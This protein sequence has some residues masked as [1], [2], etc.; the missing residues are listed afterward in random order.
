MKKHLTFRRKLIFVII[1][2]AFC[3]EI[4]AQKKQSKSAE[5]ARNFKSGIWKK[6][7]PYF[8]SPPEYAGKFGDY[9]SPLKF[10]DGKVVN[11][12]TDWKKRR[13]EILGQWHELMGE[14]PALLKDQEME[15][16]DSARRDGFTQHRIRFRWTPREKT[17]GYLLIPNG[18]DK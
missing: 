11:T 4:S 5:H 9:R 16:L 7:A 14:W 10:Y 1:L 2:L 17:E 13:E 6:I 3:S 15:I 8:S 18:G 12:K